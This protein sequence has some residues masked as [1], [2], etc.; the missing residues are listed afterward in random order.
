MLRDLTDVHGNI[1]KGTPD[2]KSE[3]GVAFLKI[4]AVYGKVDRF[5]ALCRQTTVTRWLDKVKTISHSEV[6]DRQSERL[7]LHCIDLAQLFP[8]QTPEI[9]NLRQAD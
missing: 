3:A 5:E 7:N 4:K 8:K 1:K 6:S 9:C 2:P